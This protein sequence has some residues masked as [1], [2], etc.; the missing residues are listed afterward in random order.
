MRPRLSRLALLSVLASLPVLVATTGTASAVDTITIGGTIDGSDGRAVNAIIGLDL[1]D[2]S[3]QTLNAD[4]TPR[5]AAGYG[6]VV[7]VN[8]G[9][10]DTT[11]SC[12]AGLPPEGTSDTS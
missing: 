8:Q 12:S 9:D 1:K 2:A 11:R 3:G 4:G 5:T 7:H 10:F 6:L